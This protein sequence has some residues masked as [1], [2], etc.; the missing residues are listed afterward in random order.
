MKLTA[1]AAAGITI[2]VKSGHS[3]ADLERIVTIMKKPVAKGSLPDNPYLEPKYK[4]KLQEIG[5]EFPSDKWPQTV[6]HNKKEIDDFVLDRCRWVVGKMR[7]RPSSCD[8]KCFP[9]YWGLPGLRPRQNS[10]KNMVFVQGGG[11]FITVIMPHS[12]SYYMYWTTMADDKDERLL[13]HNNN[14]ELY[15][16]V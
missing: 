15:K 11:I 4:A 12:T 9:C 5:Y 14:E 3:A 13:R 1:C 2:P 6:C 10:T 7:K 16:V 8:V